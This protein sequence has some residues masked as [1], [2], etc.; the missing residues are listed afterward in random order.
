MQHF[1]SQMTA[2]EKK[3]LLPR[4]YYDEKTDANRVLEENENRFF[5]KKHLKY[6]GAITDKDSTMRNKTMQ[7]TTGNDINQ[8]QRQYKTGICSF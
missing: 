3:R 2:I 6:F 8:R 7:Y 4:G 1:Q 5:T